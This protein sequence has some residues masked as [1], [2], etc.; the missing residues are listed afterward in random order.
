MPKPR[1]LIVDDSRVARMRL[2]N[3]AAECGWEVVAEAAT[4]S[5]GRRL[6]QDHR[7]DLT[8]LDIGLPDG[9]GLGVLRA[10]RR[11]SADAR[12]VLVSAVGDRDQIADGV[13]DG[14][15]DF[16]IKPFDPDRL[17][18][19]LNRVASTLDERSPHIGDDPR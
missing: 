15:M 7:P 13:N 14:A 17:A 4:A 1:L 19:I 8:T 16:L 18:A 5:D 9:S 10:I 3:V 2:R 11:D 6:H 12:V